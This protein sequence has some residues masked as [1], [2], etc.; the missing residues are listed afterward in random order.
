M[1]KHRD[2]FTTIGVRKTLSGRVG[3]VASLMNIPKVDVVENSFELYLKELVARKVIPKKW[4]KK[5]SPVECGAKLFTP[6]PKNTVSETNIVGALSFIKNAKPGLIL[7][8]GILKSVEDSLICKTAKLHYLLSNF[9]IIEGKARGIIQGTHINRIIIKMSLNEKGGVAEYLEYF[10]K[11]VS[12]WKD[13][14]EHEDIFKIVK[15]LR[16]GIK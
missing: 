14:F 4:Q 11:H 10:D 5:T 2:M 12:K 16:E 3:Q 9:F 1:P 8:P 13:N 15:E 6:E 7:A